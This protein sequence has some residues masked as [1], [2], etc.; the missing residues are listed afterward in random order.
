MPDE[1][2]FFQANCPQNCPCLLIDFCLGR[3]LGDFSLFLCNQ[4]PGSS[5]QIYLD[6]GAPIVILANV[7]FWY[8]KCKLDMCIYVS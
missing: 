3:L 1:S 7:F 4:T 2:L 8:F 5:S 6:S